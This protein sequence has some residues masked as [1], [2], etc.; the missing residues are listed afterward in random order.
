VTPASPEG[1]PIPEAPAATPEAPPSTPVTE[2]TG[3]GRFARLRRLLPYFT[4]GWAL[5]SATLMKRTPERAWLVAVSVAAG[6]LF[7]AGAVVLARRRSAA[8]EIGLRHRV[9]TFGATAATQSLMQL[10]LFFV[11]PF[12]WLS[13]APLLPHWLFLVFAALVAGLTLWDPLFNRVFRVPAAAVALKGATSFVGLAAALP[14]LG[15]SHAMSLWMAAL[16][17]A[18]GVPLVALATAAPADRARALRAAAIV[19]ALLPLGVFLGGGPLDAA[20]AAASHRIRARHRREPFD[21]NPRRPGDGLPPRDG[22]SALFHGH[23]RPTGPA[24]SDLPRLDA[25]RCPAL[26]RHARRRRQPQRGVA[27]LVQRER[28]AARSLPL[29]GRHEYGSAPGPARCGGRA[30]TGRP[31]HR[32][33]VPSV[34]LAALSVVG[35]REHSTPPAATATPRAS[36]LEVEVAGCATLRLVGEHPVCGPPPDRR[37]R[38][39]VPADA[40]AARLT[41]AKGVLTPGQA[42]V[43]V[44]DEGATEVSVDAGPARFAL[45]VEPP[46]PEP[47]LDELT[48]L[49]KARRLDEARI[50]ADALLT[51]PPPALAGRLHGQ[52]ARIALA[53]GDTE[54]AAH[55][56]TAAAPL[57][58][59]DGRLSDRVNDAL[60]LAFVQIHQ[61]RDFS[62]ARAYP[63]RRRTVCP[64]RPRGRRGPAGPPRPTRARDR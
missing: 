30:V 45:R 27:Y 29:R 40:S 19:A 3:P 9:V 44:V 63:G 54:R 1:E 59:A 37:L 23:L 6:W 18:A 13:A 2:S 16:G 48:A 10:T 61:L 28:F 33:W 58:A 41:G 21:A 50:R 12:Y 8:A 25:E 14:F 46:A 15:L 55:H 52:A 22:S 49:R 42:A 51:A 11:L 31:S 60:A 32:W 34:V 64:L 38:L 53:S 7:L 36:P 43:I 35:C 5:T 57:H 24:R 4:L 47:A 56:F 62:G 39:V 20:G 26:P 17:S